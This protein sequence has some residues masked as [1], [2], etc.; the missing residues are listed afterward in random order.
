MESPGIPEPN[1]SEVPASDHRHK[2]PAGYRVR[3]TS[4]LGRLHHEYSLVNDA[5]NDKFCFFAEN[6]PAA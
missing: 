4:L 3:K 2:L 5:P 6:T 1:Q